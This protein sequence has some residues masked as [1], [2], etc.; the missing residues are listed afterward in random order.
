MASPTPSQSA[1]RISPG[2]PGAL[3][4]QSTLVGGNT[5]PSHTTGTALTRAI[6]KFRNKLTGTELTEF[7]KSTYD[8]LGKALLDVQHQQEGRMET[9]N[10]AR[11]KPCLEAMHQFGQVIEIFLNV[12]DAVA[13]FWGPMKFILL[14]GI[15]IAH[16][17]DASINRWRR[18]PAILQTHLSN[19]WMR[20]RESANS[21]LCWPNTSHCSTNHPI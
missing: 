17:I 5:P 7:S 13:F 4:Q 2:P 11:I 6:T 21:C 12:A 1:S 10:L 18:Q 19:F 20:M 3:S 15:L 16:T 9:M 8:D 14:V